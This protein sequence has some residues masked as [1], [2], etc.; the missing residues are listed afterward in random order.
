[1]ENPKE[2][3]NVMIEYEATISFGAYGIKKRKEVVLRRGFY[4]KSDGYYNHKD[5][6]VETPDGI[7]SVPHNWQSFT[8]SNGTSS[9]MPFGFGH[10]RLS[11]NDVIEWK[12][13]KD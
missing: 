2:Y 3:H 4:S 5:E 12:Y 8:F 11:P 7:F 10:T 9:L 1:M 13:C 6:W